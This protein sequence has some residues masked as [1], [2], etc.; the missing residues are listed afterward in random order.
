MQRQH[1]KHVEDFQIQGVAF[2]E[3]DYLKTAQSTGSTTE[4]ITLNCDYIAIYDLKEL[5]RDNK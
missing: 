5:M 1:V 4:K 2:A 3:E